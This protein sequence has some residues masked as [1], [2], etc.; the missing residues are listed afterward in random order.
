LTIRGPFNVKYCHI[1]PGEVVD[2]YNPGSQVEEAGYGVKGEHRLYIG[3]YLKK[4]EKSV[5][6][7]LIIYSM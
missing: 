1:L 6:S 4:K 7:I 3:S 2:T 5:M